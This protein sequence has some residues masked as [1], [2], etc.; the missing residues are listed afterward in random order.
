MAAWE[1][2]AAR[3]MLPAVE[4]A[5]EHTKLW[6]AAALLMAA[7][8]GRRGRKAAAAGAPAIAVA[9]VLSNGVAKQLVE[10]RRPP[11]E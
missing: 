4:E 2:P 7:A 11:T 8:G 10:R 6:R 9:E 1:S 5:A 3:R